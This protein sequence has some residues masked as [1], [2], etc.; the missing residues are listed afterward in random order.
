MTR[1]RRTFM[2]AADWPAMWF[3]RHY[4]RMLRRERMAR[5]R[6]RGWA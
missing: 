5:K 1:P 6:R 4:Q 2:G 3:Y